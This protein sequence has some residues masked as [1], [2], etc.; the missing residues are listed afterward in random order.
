MRCFEE[1]DT[2]P[3]SNGMVNTCLHPHKV[4]LLHRKLPHLRGPAESHSFYPK[5]AGQHRK[6]GPH[7]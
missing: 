6:T 5:E 7:M 2:A 1:K 3:Y 4:Q